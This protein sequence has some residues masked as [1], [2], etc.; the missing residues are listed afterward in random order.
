LV[1]RL[2]EDGLVERRIAREDARIHRLHATAAGR[3][4]IARTRS[5]TQ[6]LN[7]ALLAPFDREE[8]KTIEA[9]LEHVVR[10]AG[11]V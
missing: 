2:V 11:D 4:L 6:R 3:A 7:A 1:D 10:E 8:R 5:Q 9:F